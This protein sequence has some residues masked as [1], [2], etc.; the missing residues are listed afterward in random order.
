MS[1]RSGNRQIIRILLVVAAG[2]TVVALPRLGL[3]PVAILLVVML[4]GYMLRQAT[5]S[6]V[7]DFAARSGLDAPGPTARRFIAHHLTT[8]RRLRVVLVI[9]ALIVP[10]VVAEAIAPSPDGNVSA[11]WSW[12]LWACMAG[13]L[14]AELSVTRP[15]GRARV[16]SLVPREPEAYLGRPLRWGPLAA[17]LVAT[18]VWIG[19]AFL[20]AERT[21]GPG[22]SAG[23]AAER[24]SGLDIAIG[25][26]FVLVV[27]LVVVLAQRWILRRP[28]PLVAPDLVAA[29]DAVRAASV[30]NLAA[31]GTALVLLYL[32]GGLLQYVEVVED[33]TVD[34]SAGLASTLCLALAIVSW[35]S[36]AWWRPVRRQ[37]FV[38]VDAPA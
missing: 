29:D 10:N 30:R 8:G 9:G 11:S 2:M 32:A 26:A 5:G 17:A 37:V 28:Q 35:W 22:A 36:R 7:A 16:A 23:D 14:W 38:P 20:P 19:V 34:W 18:G 33:T 25:I 27:P 12:M 15:T 4:I 1:K 13:T 6:D 21:G 31:V 3:A 24:A